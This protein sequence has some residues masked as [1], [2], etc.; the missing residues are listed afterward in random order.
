M[1]SRE[2]VMQLYR[3]GMIYCEIAGRLDCSERQVGRIVRENVR[4]IDRM[5]HRFA[6][7]GDEDCVWIAL[8]IYNG[9]T[10]IA[11]K[12]GL[13]PQAIEQAITPH[14]NRSYI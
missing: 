12:C 10:W 7:R 9:M 8:A 14:L 1:I 4:E 13:T 11:A 5:W 3:R 6:R 2:R